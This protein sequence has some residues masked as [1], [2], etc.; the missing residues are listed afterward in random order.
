MALTVAVP[1]AVPVERVGN[2]VVVSS[3]VVLR[4]VLVGVVSI[5]EL[6]P[7][8]RLFLW[9]HLG[10]LLGLVLWL[11]RIILLSFCS[12]GRWVLRTCMDPSCMQRLNKWGKRLLLSLLLL[13]RPRLLQQRLRLYLLRL[14]CL[15]LPAIPPHLLDF[16]T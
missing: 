11:L 15:R 3:A 9:L 4:A 14:W 8:L 12:K 2:I 13:R 5:A 16:C 6:L 7:L 1:V 10:L